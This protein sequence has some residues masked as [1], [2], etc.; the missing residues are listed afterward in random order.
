MISAL[1][2]MLLFAACGARKGAGL[3]GPDPVDGGRDGGQDLDGTAGGDAEPDADTVCEDP[4]NGCG[5]DPGC[6]G[7]LAPDGQCLCS[8]ERPPQT[9]C[10]PDTVETTCDTCLSF[11][12]VPWFCAEI[13]GDGWRWRRADDVVAWSTCTADQMCQ[14]RACHTA[15]GNMRWVCDGATFRP[16]AEVPDC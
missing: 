2:F 4:I 6:D 15:A 14:A 9:D 7:Q 3:P 8:R 1:P 16:E 10:L 13:P 5:Y 12:S 11:G